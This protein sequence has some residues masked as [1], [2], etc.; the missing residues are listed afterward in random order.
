MFDDFDLDLNFHN[1]DLL[2]QSALKSSI[3]LDISWKLRD[4][5]M[6]SFYDH[7]CE[8]PYQIIA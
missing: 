3:S 7:P 8:I 6:A 1:D 4:T 5:I 2:D